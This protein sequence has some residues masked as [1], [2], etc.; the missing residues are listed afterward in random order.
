MNKKAKYIKRQLPTIVVDDRNHLLGVNTVQ[1]D[2][3]RGHHAE[4]GAQEGKVN[5]AISSNVETEN[6]NKTTSNNGQ[7]CL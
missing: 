2:K 3:K 5:L 1:G 4:E 6:N 7:G